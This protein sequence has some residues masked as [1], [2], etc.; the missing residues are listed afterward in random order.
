MKQ[1]VSVFVAI[2]GL[3]LS[4][5]ER[6]RAGLVLESAVAPGGDFGDTL[7]D[8]FSLAPGVDEVLAH[9]CRDNCVPEEDEYDYFQFTGLTPGRLYRLETVFN[10][11][12][13]S[14]PSL[15]NPIGETPEGYYTVPGS[16]VVGVG[17][18]VGRSK[19]V[20]YY[21]VKLNIVPVPEP[22]TTAIFGV[23]LVILALRRRNKLRVAD[24]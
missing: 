19:E 1:L 15:I 21:Q 18:G 3:T 20:G 9:A 24:R 12:D 4:Y 23:G 11:L 6:S 2:L 14:H 13:K 5:T 8:I 22:G 16:G 7:A 10:T 17:F